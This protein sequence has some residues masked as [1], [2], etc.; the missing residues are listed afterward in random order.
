MISIV[1]ITFNNHDELM[2]TIDSIQGVSEIESVVINGGSSTETV[3]FLQSYSGKSISEKDRGISDAFNK[4]LRNSGGDAILFLNSGD[5]LIDK[6]YIEEANKLLKNPE[7]DFIYADIIFEDP[8]IG[9]ILLKSNRKLPNMPFNHPTLIVR[10]EV[11]EK[12]GE[13]D[14]NFK[15]AMDLDFVYRML[16]VTHKGHY[17]PRAVVKMDGRGVSSSQHLKV[18]KERK[19]VIIKN[20]DFSLRTKVVILKQFS[21]LQIKNFLKVIG[22][23]SAINFYRK[24]KF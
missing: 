19:A 17:I 10:K 8:S 21:N 1:T 22:L 20:R 13:F 18:L 4:G 5:T 2:N 12:A 16:K 7:I 6:T 11:F 24:L 15:I 14:L 3:K 9:D 23:Q